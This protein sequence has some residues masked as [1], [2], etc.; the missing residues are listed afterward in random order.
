MIPERWPTST[1]VAEVMLVPI[2][3]KI[4]PVAAARV[5]DN[6]CDPYR[7]ILPQLPKMLQED[8][9]TRI[10]LL[11]RSSLVPCSRRA[12]IPEVLE[13]MAHGKLH[14]ESVT[15]ATVPLDDALGRCRN[16]VTS[17]P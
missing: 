6:V 16:I 3:A 5:A 11:Q 14:S 8:P 9:G 15:T 1:R 12:I 13:L 17:T 2:P 10:F 4:E 7:R